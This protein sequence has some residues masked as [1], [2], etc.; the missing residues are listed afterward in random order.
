MYCISVLIVGLEYLVEIQ[1]SDLLHALGL[2]LQETLAQFDS[3][4][5][6]AAPRLRPEV[7]RTTV[8]SERSLLH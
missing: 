5:F 7:R 4:R 1:R 8:V 3:T 2:R 6:P